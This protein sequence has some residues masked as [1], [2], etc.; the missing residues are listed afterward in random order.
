METLR[1]GTLD[2]SLIVI[3]LIVIGGL[4]LWFSRG[5]KTG[6]DFFLAIFFAMFVAVMSNLSDL[7]VGII[8]SFV[9]IV[10]GGGS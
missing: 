6:K 3:Y 5:I 10:E 1:L 7:M 2:I 8:E 9:N 4:G